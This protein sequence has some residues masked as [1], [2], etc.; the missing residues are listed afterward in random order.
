LSMPKSVIYKPFPPGFVSR[1][2]IS[3]ARHA[4]IIGYMA[5]CLVGTK[6]GQYLGTQLRRIYQGPLFVCGRDPART[7]RLAAALG[8]QDAL[9]GW[10]AAVD[11]PGIDSVILAVPAHLHLEAGRA[12][13]LAGKHVL[14]EKPLATS[15]A[16]CDMLIRA[17]RSAGV[18]LAAGEN[19][20]FR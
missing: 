19:I 12:A 11:H 6:W 15:L 1:E 3:R 13:L 18:V 7:R 9:T 20:P 16:D 8:A 10:Q 14:L 17:A 4:R 2:A 5:V